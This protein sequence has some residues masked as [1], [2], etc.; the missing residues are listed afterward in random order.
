M[1]GGTDWFKESFRQEYEQQSAAI[2]RF[3]LAL[4]GKTGVGKS[5]LVNAIFGEDV[6]ATGIGEPVTRGS[7]LYLDR[8]GHLGI[9][10]SQGLEVGKD[11]KEIL[12]ELGKAMKE[13]RR[14]P[15]AEQIHV[16]WFCVR[17]MD[18]RF[19]EAEADFVRRLADLGLP[20]VL[21]LTQVPAR[22]GRYHPDAVELARRIEEY[23]LP[24]AGGRPFFVFA[25]ADPFADQPAHGLQDVLDATFR[26]A[27]DGVHGALVAAQTIDQARKAKEAQGYI[28]AAVTAAAGAAFIPIPFSDA[29]ALVPI[30]L[31]MMAKIAQ[32]YKI[33]VDR[34]A[35]LAIASTTAATQ[36]GRATFSGLLKMVPGAG[37]VAG[38]MMSAG[39]ATSFTYAMGQAWLVVCQRVA[40]GGLGGIGRALDDEAV[41]EAFVEEFRARLKIRRGDKSG[42]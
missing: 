14:R 25:K 39:V 18:R 19:E 26:V 36:A 21:V 4:F 34:A 33:K 3:N 35:L 40:S 16:A 9:V 12:S 31:G 37:T 6:A 7:H 28:G 2:G 8:I 10:D 15:L 23:R 5:T 29:A 32:L 22:D 24:L 17:G 11:N 41:R 42:V 13:M 27:P 30:Q 20:V 38:G 1:A